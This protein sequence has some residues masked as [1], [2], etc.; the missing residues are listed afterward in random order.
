MTRNISL[1]I[2][3]IV[4]LKEYVLNSITEPPHKYT[5]IHN[6]LYTHTHT[7]IYIYI[8]IYTYNIMLHFLGFVYP[9]MHIHW[10]LLSDADCLE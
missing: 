4:K 1:A 7:Y 8:Y 5:C 2:L 9:F 3:D 10:E 6:H